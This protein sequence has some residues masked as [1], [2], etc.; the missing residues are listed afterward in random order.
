[1]QLNMKL[2]LIVVAFALL[3][4]ASLAE[5]EPSRVSGSSETESFKSNLR[6]KRNVPV[7]VMKRII[8]NRNGDA[9]PTKIHIP[10]VAKGVKT[11]VKAFGGR[12]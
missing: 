5:S 4:L 10:N 8:M 7:E 1:M 2:V 9:E 12:R 3:T 11:F 6:L